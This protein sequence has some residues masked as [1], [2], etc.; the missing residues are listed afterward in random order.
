VQ[1]P[2]NPINKEEKKKGDQ[3]L[4]HCGS[5]LLGVGK[6]TKGGKT[7]KGHTKHKENRR[8]GRTFAVET[9]LLMG[10]NRSG[11]NN[12]KICKKKSKSKVIRLIS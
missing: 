7:E 8:D 12:G 9:K 5:P 4:S 1:N 2:G 3:H 11:G 10:L 6:R